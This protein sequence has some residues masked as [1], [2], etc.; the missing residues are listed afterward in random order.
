MRRLT[1]LSLLLACALRAWSAE[2]IALSGGAALILDK[3]ALRLRSAD[4]AELA[5]M[6]IRGRHLDYRD[7]L[8]LV[9]DANTERAMTVAVD[10]SAGTLAAQAQIDGSAIAPEASC[11]YRDG[12][13]L[14][15]AFLAGKDGQAEQWLLPPP[16]GRPQLVRKLALPPHSAQCLVHDASATLVL[17]EKG[18]GVWA[19]N[20]EAEAP[21]SRRALALAAPYGSLPAG[22]DGTPV[23]VPA[24]AGVALVDRSGNGRQEITLQRDLPPAVFVQPRVQ[25]ESMPRLGDAADDPAIWIDRRN[26]G[27]GRVLGTNKKQGLHVYDLQ[28]RQTQM[29][30]SGRLNNVDL[31]QAVRIDGKSFD[32]AAA[33]QR[34]ENSLVL[35]TIDTAGTVAEAARFPTPLERIY[36]ICL[37]Q[38]EGGG[39]SAFINDKDGSYLQYRIGRKAGAFTASIVRR[40]RLASQPEG[41]VADD[42]NARLFAGEEKRGVWTI[43]ARADNK[44]EPKLVM[45]VGGPLRADVEGM[46]IYH[47]AKASYLVV[48][49]QGSN[50]YV[51]ADAAPPHR[52][53]GSFRIG[54]NPGAGID[55]ASE[56]DGL[57]VTSANLG[58]RFARGMLVVQDGYK[59]L[60]DGAQNFKYVAWQDI[61]AALSL[62]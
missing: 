21:P 32:L 37:Y 26:P 50:S 43:D 19:Y 33:T 54:M 51:V 41:C 12:Q 52:I 28:G 4:G 49:S 15:H 11:L 45:Q 39:L 5:S 48:S 62:P 61:A 6:P 42:R 36:G 34:D 55:G 35:Y 24:P 14:L 58:G 10:T 25:T 57:D 53:R 47:G 22:E 29:L 2:T 27:Q 46:A 13:G 18:M 56:T 7:G 23:L 17:A 1:F 59:R 3:H 16:G 40:F 44:A 8:A 38:P 30:E 20:A 31:R 9:V 60:P